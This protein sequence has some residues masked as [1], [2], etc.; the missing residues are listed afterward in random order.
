MAGKNFVVAGMMALTA[1]QAEPAPDIDLPGAHP[2]AYEAIRD[3]SGVL[4]YSESLLGP[5]LATKY[6]T[7]LGPG[8]SYV[9][10]SVVAGVWELP[11]SARA[12]QLRQFLRERGTL[13]RIRDYSDGQLWIADYQARGRL[14]VRLLL[15]DGAHPAFETEA[16]SEVRPGPHVY[17][18]AYRLT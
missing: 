2:I 8:A 10:R 18:I 17:L 9:D 6:E 15:I 12:D 7:R 4:G 14:P 13:D 1:C 3:A 5:T 16:V 11:P